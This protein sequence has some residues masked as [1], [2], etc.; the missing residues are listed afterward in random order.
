M[1]IMDLFGKVVIITGA[2]KGIGAATAMAFASRGCKVVLSARSENDLIEISRNAG[3]ENTLVV[4]AD[5]SRRDD[6]H[7]LVATTLEHFDRIDILV[8]N[9]GIGLVAPVHQMCPED[10]TTVFAT[11]LFGVIHCMQEVIPVMQ[12]A[13]GG[14]IM[15]VSSMITRIAT[16]GSG[17]YRAS[18]CALNAITDAARLELRKHNIRVIA[19]YPGLTATRFFS[20]CA[21]ITERPPV[22]YGEKQLRGRTPEFVANKIVNSARSEPSAVYMSPI[23]ALCGSFAQMFPGYVETFLQLRKL[24]RKER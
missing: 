11:N 7:S 12:S 2:S 22:V 6:V 3:R 1:S 13:N 15:N 8:N 21:G 24:I 14:I 5:V 18:K 16:T 10:L 20:H 19:V 17:G 23:S 4:P 9:A